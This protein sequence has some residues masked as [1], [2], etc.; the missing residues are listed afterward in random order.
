MNHHS[1]AAVSLPLALYLLLSVWYFELII[2]LRTVNRFLGIG[3]LYSL[4]FAAAFAGA[5]AFVC[6]LSG[7]AHFNRCL[8]GWLLIVLGVYTGVQIVYFGIFKTY[9]TFSSL[10]APPR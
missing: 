8:A 5:L 7:S 6:T 3:L 10:G 1:I 2:R 9:F 4:L